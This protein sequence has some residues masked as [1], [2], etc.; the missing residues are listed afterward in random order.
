[1]L[2]LLLV[3]TLCGEYYIP[4]RANRRSIEI[5]KA[6]NAM[7]QTPSAPK[8]TI[9][10]KRHK[11]YCDGVEFPWY[12]AERGPT[13]EGICTHNEVPIVSIPIIASDLEV[14]PISTE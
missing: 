5:L 10:R 1:M 4:R 12:I 14:I 3:L 9:D 2:T 7:T 8:I 11:V 6:V 13:V